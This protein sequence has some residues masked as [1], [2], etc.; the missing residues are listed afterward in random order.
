M[1]FFFLSSQMYDT[2]QYIT[3]YHTYMLIII[4][5]K[6]KSVVVAVAGNKADMQHSGSFDLV[7]AED[8]C[9]SLKCE[10]HLT[11]AYSGEVSTHVNAANLTIFYELM[12]SLHKRYNK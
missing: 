11:S 6:K 10:F 12:R 9:A 5:K 4:G 1:F 7:K 2:V 3:I 8:M